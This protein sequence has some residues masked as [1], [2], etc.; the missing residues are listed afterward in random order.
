MVRSTSGPRPISGSTRPSLAFSLRLTVNCLSAD[1]GFFLPSSCLV[2]SA[3]LV[4]G[5][6]GDRLALADAVADIGDRVEAAHVLLLQEIDG[7]ALAL[8]EERDEHVGAGHLVAARRL[9]VEDGALDDAL[10]AAGRRRVGLAF[11]LERFEL[12]V[13][14]VADRVAQLAEIDAAGL[15]DAAGMDVLDQG[16]KQM[17]ERR[18]FV[19]AAARLGEGVVERLLELAGE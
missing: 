14:I 7:I 9:D 4:S 13:E 12:V 19:P 8:G 18:I 3:P 2:S 1:S 15:H 17:L 6:L 16:E 5:G 10:E 11:D